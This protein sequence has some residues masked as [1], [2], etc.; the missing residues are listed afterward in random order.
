MMGPDM[1]R[2]PAASVPGRDTTGTALFRGQCA[3]CHTLETEGESAIG[4]NLHHL[5]GRRA[6]RLPGYS[7]SP[8]MR[9][10]GVVWGEKTLDGFL[11]DPSRFVP[12]NKMPFAGIRDERQRQALI[13]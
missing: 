9:R 8:A 5:F 10:S 3:A 2:G 12:G 11:A 6:G 13:A 4:P 1:M 7:Y